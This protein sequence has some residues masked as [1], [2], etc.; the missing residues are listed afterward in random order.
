LTDSRATERSFEETMG[1][2][3][4]EQSQLAYRADF[5][6]YGAAIAGLTAFLI[7]DVPVGHGVIA[8]AWVFA[9]IACWTAVEYALHRFVLHGL[10]PFRGWH[11]AHHRRPSALICA[12]T[13]FSALLIFV[14]VF[15][16]ARW[17]GGQWPACAVTL[18]VVIGYY[19]YAFTH[20][21]AH[22]WKHDN[23]WLRRRKRWHALHHHAPEPGCFGVTS[24]L[25][26]VVFGSARIKRSRAV[27]PAIRSPAGD[28]VR[29]S[30]SS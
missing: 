15:L 17:I 30:A 27:R 7:H 10:W 22:H 5:A 3:T 9:G 2:M 11:E 18:G 20:H 24:S 28:R 21:A 12:P 8:A 16:P 23:A 25:W 26:D 4:L 1:L 29:G 19:A 13:I 14:L 6:F